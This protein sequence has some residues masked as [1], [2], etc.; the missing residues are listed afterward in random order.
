V[1]VLGPPVPAGWNHAMP[2]RDLMRAIRTRVGGSFQD[3][4]SNLY[5]T[6]EGGSLGPEGALEENPFQGES[7]A[8]AQGTSAN[9]VEGTP[10]DSQ[11]DTPKTDEPESAKP[12]RRA[13]A[14]P[15]AAVGASATLRPLML[16]WIGEDGQL[17]HTTVDRLGEET[18]GSGELGAKDFDFLAFNEPME[19][20]TAATVADF[21]GD[22]NAD[23]GFIVSQ[24]GYF[25]VFLANED[26]TYTEGSRVEVGRGPRSLVAG[27]FNRDGRTDVAISSVGTGLVTV[28][29]SDPA[30]YFRYRTLWLDTYRDYVNAADTRQAGAP[31]LVGME[32]SEHANV[33]LDFSM[34]EGM[35]STRVFDYSPSLETQLT[36]QGG[37]TVRLNAVMLGNT[38]S[39]NLDN[40]A[41]QMVNTVN[42]AGGANA[43]L[44]LGDLERDG[45]IRVAVAKP[46]H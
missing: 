23:I 43:C 42:L 32:F 28:L 31:D 38:L 46:K 37:R 29:F 44:I 36:A 24:Q 18:F 33:L 2:N 5:G 8:A 30:S 1:L 13:G 14:L 21:N 6:S 4:L 22:G 3:F 12:E 41:G 10:S 25:R 39:L 34:P 45:S 40:R 7:E 35:P 20:P 11:A 27:D 17:Y 19:F 26:G 15:S 9:A 16:M